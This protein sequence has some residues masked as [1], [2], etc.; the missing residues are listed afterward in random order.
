MSDLKIRVF[1]NGRTDPSTTVSIPGGILKI[2]ANLIPN[3]AAA[4][5]QEEGID[6]D[7]LA[8]LSENPEAQGT[9]VTIDDHDKNE[10]VVIALE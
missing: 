10:Q 9:L 2:A 5:L 1:K 7:E 6:L 8:R 4:K 3:R